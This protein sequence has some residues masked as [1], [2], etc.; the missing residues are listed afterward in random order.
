MLD[1]Q[2]HAIQGRRHR[3]AM[4]V[5]L[6]ALR[7]HEERNKWLEENYAGVMWQR[8]G[9]YWFCEVPG[10][11]KALTEYFNAPSRNEAIDKAMRGAK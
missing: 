4:A 8:A 2:Q 10:G 7:A 6:A 5:E 1:D 11:P 3:E 9:Q